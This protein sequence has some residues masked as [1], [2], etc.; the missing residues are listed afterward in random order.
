M[1]HVFQDESR[2]IQRRGRARLSRHRAPAFGGKLLAEAEQAKEAS[3]RDA[4]IREILALSAYR[5]GRCDVALRKLRTFRRFTGESTHVL[6]EMEVLRALDRPQDYDEVL[7]PPGCRNLLP[8][9]GC[10]PR[11]R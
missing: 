5:L 10:V 3:P 11:T 2:R 6:V 1:R 8:Q 7:Q 4:T 9:G